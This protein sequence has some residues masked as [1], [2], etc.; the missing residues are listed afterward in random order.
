MRRLCLAIQGF[1]EDQGN[2]ATS[3]SNLPSDV[4]K[5]EDYLEKVTIRMISTATM[6]M[7]TAV[8]SFVTLL[9]IGVQNRNP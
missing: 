7:A 3:F 8:C 2:V 5:L 9:F 4:E 6:A 1:D